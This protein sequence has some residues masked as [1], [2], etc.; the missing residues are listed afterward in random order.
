MSDRQAV[1]EATDG[2]VDLVAGMGRDDIFGE[3]RGLAD[4]IQ[5]HLTILSDRKNILAIIREDLIAVKDEFAVPRA[6]S[7][8]RSARPS[9]CSSPPTSRPRPPSPST[10]RPRAIWAHP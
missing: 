2:M 4:T 8:R 1:T 9:W 6:N 5:G 7:A 10:L 3:A